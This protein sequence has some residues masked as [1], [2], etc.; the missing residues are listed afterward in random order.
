MTCLFG[1]LYTQTADVYTLTETT[2]KQTGQKVKEWVFNE[3]TPCF[4][5]PIS[6]RGAAGAAGE[7]YG[8]LYKS[9]SHVRIKVPERIALTSKITNIKKSSDESVIWLED[10]GLPTVFE[11]VGV[12]PLIDAFSSTMGYEIICNKSSDQRLSA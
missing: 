7:A 2:N 3:T 12:V 9:Y 11:V 5:A 6:T 10:T 8:T 4:A 1:S